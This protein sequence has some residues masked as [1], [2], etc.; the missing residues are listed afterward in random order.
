MKRYLRRKTKNVMDERTVR[1]EVIRK[2][3]K[4]A[5]GGREESRLSPVLS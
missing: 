5:K 2:K 4:E 1:M 3:E